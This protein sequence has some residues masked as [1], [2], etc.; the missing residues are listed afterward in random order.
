M[1]GSMRVYSGP[2][3]HAVRVLEYHTHVAFKNLIPVLHTLSR[4]SGNRMW[5]S[6]RSLLDIN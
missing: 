4:E 2:M 6:T 5:K 1:A 3:Y